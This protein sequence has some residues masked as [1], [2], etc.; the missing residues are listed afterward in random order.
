ME[1]ADAPMFRG[2]AGFISRS[3]DMLEAEGLP[4]GR[5]PC[6]YHPCLGR[7]PMPRSFVALNL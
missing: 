7:Q 2:V 1:A 6:S 3:T 4:A 5:H